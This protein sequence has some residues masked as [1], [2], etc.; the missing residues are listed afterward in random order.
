MF[1]NELKGLTYLPICAF[2]ARMG[3]TVSSLSPSDYNPRKISDKQLDN[4]GKAMAEF[5]DLSGII[6]NV[7]TNRIVGGHQRIKKLAPAWEII[8]EPASDQVGTVALGH[9]ET[10]FGRWQYREVDWEEKKE[11][12]ANVAANKHGGEW[13][14]PKLKDIL[15]EL[16]DGAF[17]MDLTGF[18][19]G[20]LKELIDWEGKQGSGVS[21]VDVTELHDK[22][23]I[24]IRGDLKYQAEAIKRMKSVLKEINC[25]CEIEMG[26]NVSE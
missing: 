7:R 18:G 9:I 4:L 6:F 16:D 20:E 22:F 2:I 14:F 8:K 23:W 15:V 12:A 10:P 3:K 25:E 17:D 11:L 21:E 26:L 13:D 5:G 24:S 19:E 1:K